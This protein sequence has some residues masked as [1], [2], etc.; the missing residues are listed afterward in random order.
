MQ[1][2]L[3]VRFGG[4]YGEKQ[5]KLLAPCLPYWLAP[6]LVRLVCALQQAERHMDITFVDPDVVE[7]RNVFRQNFCF[8]EL[9][10]P[11]A[12][13]LAIDPMFTILP[14]PASSIRRPASWHI[15]NRPKTRFSKTCRICS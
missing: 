13:T 15:W 7:A 11:K 14:I 1:G 2:N 8:A 3:H 4:G 6:D 10:R 5:V 12:V 9:G